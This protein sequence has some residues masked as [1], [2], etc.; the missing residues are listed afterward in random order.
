MRKVF[1]SFS[2]VYTKALR[3]MKISLTRCAVWCL[4]SSRSNTVVFACPYKNNWPAFSKISSVGTVFEN[5]R[6]WCTKTPFTCGRKAKTG[7]KIY[8]FKNNR[9]GV[10]GT[11]NNLL[12]VSDW[13]LLVEFIHRIRSKQLTVVGVVDFM[14]YLLFEFQN[15]E[16]GYLGPEALLMRWARA[17]FRFPGLAGLMPYFLLKLLWWF[18]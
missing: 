6:C 3:T 8:V 13:K 9:I 4:P 18:L 10:D 5:L 14:L 7:K 2:L 1:E 12:K 15:D 11:W 17:R 16:F